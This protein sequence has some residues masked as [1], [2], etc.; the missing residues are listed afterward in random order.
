[1]VAVLANLLVGTFRL[2]SLEAR[3]SDGEIS[4]PFGRN[5]LGMFIFDRDGNLAVQ[6]MSTDQTGD[7]GTA[8]SGFTAMFGT[9]LVDEGQQTFR[10]SLEGA[11][12]SALI[13][14]E[15]L[16]YVHFSDDLAIFNTPPQMTDG[17]ETTTYIT[18]Q[19][20]SPRVQPE[21]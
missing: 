20:V 7:E 3:R 11:S 19:K 16:R 1:L 14:T 13:G 12:H 15:I 5:P 2:V 6:L 17:V 21:S 10:A 18:W 4:H 8:G 9:Y